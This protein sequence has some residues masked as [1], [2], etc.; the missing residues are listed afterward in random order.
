METVSGRVVQRLGAEIRTKA[1]AVRNGFHDGLEGHRVVGSGERVG[2]AEIDLVLARS[3]LMMRAFRSDA[4]LFKRQTDLTP[5]VFTAVIG[6]EIHIARLVIGLLG[7]FPVLV[8][9]EKIK[10]LLRAECKTVSGVRNRLLQQAAGIALK[11]TAVG[12]GDGG[13][14]THDLAMLGTPGQQHQR[15]RLRMQQQIGV[16]LV[17]EAGDG[18]AVERNPICKRAWQFIRHNRYIL[19]SAEHVAEGQADEL[20]IFFL[21]ILHNLLLGISHHSAPLPLNL[22]RTSVYT[23]F[24]CRALRR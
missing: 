2:I 9:T 4:H 15:V 14:H 21:H 19:L 24:Y 13:K 16:R 17:A 20:H 7:R 11:G 6:R 18:G 12:V 1:V 23:D 22:Q 10:L 5:D 3:F 8:K